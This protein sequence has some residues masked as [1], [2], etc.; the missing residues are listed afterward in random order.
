MAASNLEI[1]AASTA[2]TLAT[3]HPGA[4]LPCPSCAAFV[5]ATNLPSHL[6]S[7]H[8]LSG[9]A[10]APARFVLQGRDRYARRPLGV[11]FVAWAVLAGAYVGV[12]PAFGDWQAGVLGATFV[13]AFAPLFA[14]LFD[15]LPARVE[16][17]GARVRLRVLFGLVVRDVTLPARI[18]S[19]RILERRPVP[20]TGAMESPPAEEVQIG[21]FLRL[22]EG[23]R[24]VTFGARKAAGL[25]KGW[26]ASGWARAGAARRW[27]VTVD[28]N[29]LVALEYWLASHGLL[30]PRTS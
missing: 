27:D 26:D 20:G 29:A 8:G 16:I 7:A 25:A 17:E 19:G 9:A 30:R 28:R 11:L 14:A 24:S 12:T 2:R 18:E 6:E 22:S 1:H 15:W 5:R 3:A 13:L 21:V 23:E 4:T 10:T